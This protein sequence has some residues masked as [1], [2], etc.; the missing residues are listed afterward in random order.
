MRPSDGSGWLDEVERAATAR[1]D[2]PE[3]VAALRLSPTH[4]ARF[5]VTCGAP[6]PATPP[7]DGAE[8]FP[9]YL[10]A[11]FGWGV[12]PPDEELR[13]DGLAAEDA[14]GFPLAGGEILGGGQT[15]EIERYPVAGET[16]TVTRSVEDVVRKQGRS[17]P[18]LLVRVRRDVTD[19]AGALICRC[20]ESFVVRRS[21]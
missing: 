20:R 2:A 15:V 18:F 9:L 8:A 14:L 6:P 7:A 4:A 12:G 19:R 11:M 13:P 21:S 17:G 16:V 5:A 10:A 3:V 1:R